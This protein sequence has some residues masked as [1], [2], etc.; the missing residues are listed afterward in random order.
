[1]NQNS[2]K[3]AID[4][5]L[6]KSKPDADLQYSLEWVSPQF[7]LIRFLLIDED[8]FSFKF[9][10]DK[11]T[12]IE[13]DLFES[14][15]QPNRNELVVHYDGD[16]P[17]LSL[18]NPLTGEMKV[19]SA[20]YGPTIK[21]ITVS[22]TKDPLFLFNSGDEHH[23][24]DIAANTIINIPSIKNKDLRTNEY[25]YHEMFSNRFYNG[26]TY[27]VVGS[28][29]LY[30][31]DLNNFNL[32][33]LHEFDQPVYGISSSPDGK[34]IAVLY[35][36][37]EFVGPSADLVV[38]NN[39]GKIIDTYE[40]AAFVSHSD[41]FL[42]EYP[43]SWQDDN[44]I[45]LPADINEGNITGEVLLNINDKQFT[46]IKDEQITDQMIEDIIAHT[47]E[48]NY[49]YLSKLNW[50]PDD[51]LVA[52]QA[53]SNQIWIYDPELRTFEFI[54]VGILLGWMSD[55]N[56]VYVNRHEQIIVF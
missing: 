33:K 38:L 23:L 39:R 32:K 8:I 19:L 42:F 1:M 20:W 37:D 21:S 25:G 3:K 9:S 56:L 17:S 50:S 12:T 28:K 16:Q 29:T 18:R 30:R 7:L 40:N 46:I 54:G 41:G 10:L 49:W 45:I 36:H 48:Q 31:I 2:L 26:Y 43:L 4:L 51:R 47:N 13:G 14:K 27:F 11:A 24:F 22:G 34:K 55:G 5:S 6:I 35:A 44:N 53:S 52:F 15:D